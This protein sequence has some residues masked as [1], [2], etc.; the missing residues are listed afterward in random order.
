[1]MSL[2]GVRANGHARLEVPA[3]WKA[4]LGSEHNAG[5]G[6]TGCSAVG[7]AQPSRLTMRCVNS[8]DASGL[9]GTAPV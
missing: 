9:G 6:I 3:L 7:A 4:R 8:G 1:M 5:R 2:G